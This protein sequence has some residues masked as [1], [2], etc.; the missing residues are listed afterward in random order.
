MCST[1]TDDHYDTLPA[2]PSAS[3]TQ[4]DTLPRKMSSAS[5]SSP[6][7]AT[8]EATRLSHYDTLPHRPASVKHR[9]HS[10]PLSK[11]PPSMS[12]VA[13]LSS[14]A[15]PLPN[16]PAPVRTPSMTSQIIDAYDQ[17]PFSAGTNTL[18]RTTQSQPPSK[19]IPQISKHQSVEAI[20]PAVTS[21]YDTLPTAVSTDN[22]TKPV[23]QAPSTQPPQLPSRIAAPSTPAPCKPPRLVKPVRPD[24]DP[25]VTYDVLRVSQQNA[26]VACVL[27]QASSSCVTPLSDS[28]DTPPHLV[29]SDGPTRCAPPIPQRLTDKPMLRIKPGTPTPATPEASPVVNPVINRF[30]EE[31][32]NLAESRVKASSEGADILRNKAD[33]SPRG[34]TNVRN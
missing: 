27:L 15:P 1:S 26:P 5:F 4:Y 25:D 20:S 11:A 34:S 14:R 17:F 22:L 7:S 28:E 31:L 24:V 30:S 29:D 6:S 21:L 16:R 18:P 32:T 33:S 12:K 13:P 8:M 19:P 9:N 23:A 2:S 3:F 10:P